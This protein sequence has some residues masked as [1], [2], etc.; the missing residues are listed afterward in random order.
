MILTVPDCAYIARRIDPILDAVALIFLLCDVTRVCLLYLVMDRLQGLV[1]YVRRP[2]HALLL[3]LPSCLVLNAA[4]IIR[5]NTWTGI[6]TVHT[7]S[8]IVVRDGI[9]HTVHVVSLY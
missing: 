3:Y 8:F 7:L 4:I 6:A 9:G 1:V 2:I 5:F